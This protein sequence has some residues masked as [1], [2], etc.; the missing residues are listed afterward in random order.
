[1]A[2]PCV[3]GEFFVPRYT[4]DA[5]IAEERNLCFGCGKPV[6]GLAP[7]SFVTRCKFGPQ[8]HLVE[9]RCC[10]SSDCLTYIDKCEAEFGA[11]RL[12]LV[13]RLDRVECTEDVII[14][15][16]QRLA[17]RVIVDTARACAQ[18]GKHSWSLNRVPCK[19]TNSKCARCFRVWYCSKPCQ[20]QHWNS[21]HAASC[22]TSSLSDGA[23]PKLEEALGW[24]KRNL[25]YHDTLKPLMVLYM[26]RS[27]ELKLCSRPLCRVRLSPQ[28]PLERPL[29][30]TFP[31]EG[32]RNIARGAVCF[33]SD[34][35]AQTCVGNNTILVSGRVDNSEIGGG[36]D[37]KSG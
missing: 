26:Y 36:A 24:A 2:C 33:C 10:D 21:T 6:E 20:L 15:V 29:D 34:A 23:P 17:E 14:P 28:C 25:S 22:V 27:R 13:E 7:L 30:L 32:R 19:W 4:E 16:R 3:A 31:H 35:C 11:D 1:M 9:V 8:L 18:C 12:G 37:T 5:A